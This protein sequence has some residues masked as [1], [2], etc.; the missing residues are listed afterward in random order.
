MPTWMD[1]LLRWNPTSSSNVSPKPKT[2][3]VRPE[4]RKL[5]PEKRPPPKVK[6]RPERQQKPKP[7]YDAEKEFMNTFK[8]F[9][10]KY[11]PT[12]V[13]RDF[14]VL[15]ACSVSNAVDKSHYDVREEMYLRI[16]KKYDK[17]EQN[18]FPELFAH[19]VMALEANPDQ[20]FLGKLFM[21][22]NLKNDD[23]GQF[24]TPY[25]VCEFMVKVT[26]GDLKGQ[27]EKQGFVTINDCACGAGATLIA[28]AN[29]ARR[30]LEKENLNFQNHILIT[31]Q[32]I[33]MVVGLMC[34]LQ[35]SLLGVAGYVKIG[36]SITD[37]MTADDSKENYWYTP[38]YFSDVWIMRRIFRGV[39]NGRYI[40]L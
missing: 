15:A 38:M 18:L 35:L 12:E 7:P 1:K 13:W 26:V 34:Y 24:F 28:A 23:A 10:H 21:L 14:V 22:L 20:D 5:P 11:M 27:I 39:V 2:I 32:D 31:A 36:N 30:Q 16:I 29:E 3:D 40:P 8:K 19:L 9:S 25:H 37:P 4:V 6:E 17:P 33:D